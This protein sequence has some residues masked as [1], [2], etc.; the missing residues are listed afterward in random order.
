VTKEFFKSLFDAHFDALRNYLY[1]RSGDKELAT[2]LAQECFL[3]LWEKQPIGDSVTLKRL[4]FKIGNDLFISQYRHAKI[5]RDFIFK[6]SNAGEL[7]QSPEEE[8]NY[9]EL[10]KRYNLALKEMPE[11]YRVVFLMSRSEALKNREIA[12]RLGL[13]I[14]AVEK[15]M[16]KALHYLKQVLGYDEL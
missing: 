3:K 2:D 7:S 16:S 10:E 11:N 5:E 15:R 12:E 1:Y 9:S 6:Q 13:S 4:L 14:K 8:F